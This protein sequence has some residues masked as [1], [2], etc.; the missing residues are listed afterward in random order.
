[1]VQQGRSVPVAAFVLFAFALASPLLAQRP[2]VP[3]SGETIDVSLVNVDVFVTDKKG[4][5]VT[6]LTIDDFEILEN[7]RPQ[8]VT[9]FAEYAG[10]PAN[11]RATVNARPAA[12]RQATPAPAAKRTI[13]VFVE[14]FSQPRF[15][16]KPMFEALR[17]TLHGVVRRGDSAAVIF[18]DNGSA[19]TLQDF[20]D[21]LAQLDSALTE[22][23]QQSTGVVG[24]VDFL[25][26]QA[27]F[28]D[29]YFD[30]LPPARAGA[31]TAADSMTR[32]DMLSNAQF[33]LF[34]IKM[35][36]TEL[37]AI[38]R[39][40]S[41]ED[42]RKIVLF[43][44]NDFGLY[45]R[46]AETPTTMPP[47]RFS[48][49]RTD[50]FREGVARTANEHG[51]TIYPIYPSGLGWRP[52]ASA[53]ESRPDIFRIDTDADAARMS[54]DYTSLINQTAALDEL[55]RETGGLMASGSDQVVELLPHVVEDLSNY[56]SLAYRTPDTGT[57]RSR[58]IVV[59][60]K[61]RN[62]EVRSR[63]EYVEKTDVTRMQ[64]RVIANLYRADKRGVIPVDIELGAIQQSSRTRWSVPLRI[65]VPVDALST[66]H[67]GQGEFSVFVAT[68][69]VI[70]IMSDVERR[71]QEFSAAKVSPGLKELT[72]EFTL[73]FN[74][75]TSVVSVGVLDERTK[76]YG[77]ETIELPAYRA[78]DRAGGE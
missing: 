56:Y 37:Q 78:E 54:Y 73:T 70:G 49:W 12:D 68:G 75:A 76:E 41:D 13:V 5:R 40:I 21:N 72:Y 44:T 26:K 63:R 18:W 43:A 58:D 66:L 67:D 23:E 9:N 59:K 45:P 64:D 3:S 10:D 74:G 28:A 69:G 38:M 29:A 27:A 34:Q 30:S 7:G 42:G 48:D 20:T 32:W 77:L 24:S 31:R 33:G 19:Y 36:A 11:I 22:I 50:R 35:K 4:R 47:T 61:N 57:T 52:S 51:I 55:A 71:T 65:H 8:P 6:G 14:R 15:R 46:G 25:R 1:M 62:Y 39:S 17:K 16:T 2:P 60:A 53:T